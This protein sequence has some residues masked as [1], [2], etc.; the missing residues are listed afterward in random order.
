MDATVHAVAWWIARAVELC[1]GP[2]KLAKRL[3]VTPQA[4]RFWREEKRSLP[5]EH[6]AEIELATGRQVRR[7]HLRPDDWHRIWPELVGAEGAPDLPGLP[8]EASTEAVAV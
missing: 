5:P 8:A 1:G 2:S 7:W 3:G 4:V 6:C